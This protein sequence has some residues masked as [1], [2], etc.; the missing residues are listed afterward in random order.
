MFYQLQAETEADKPQTDSG[1]EGEPTQS[2]T[3]ASSSSALQ[4]IANAF[5]RTFSV[6]NPSSSSN[7]A[8][9]MFV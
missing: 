1:Q 5:R 4:M 9:T 6:T 2:Q 7:T 3:S 8:V